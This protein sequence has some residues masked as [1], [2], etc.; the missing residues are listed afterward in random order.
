VGGGM[1][2]REITDNC[3]STTGLSRPP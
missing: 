3:S 2:N 1:N